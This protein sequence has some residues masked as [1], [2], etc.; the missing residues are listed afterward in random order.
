[1]R[2]LPLPF[3]SCSVHILSACFACVLLDNCSYFLYISGILLP[4][5]LA[6]VDALIFPT[7]HCFAT[8]KKPCAS[9]LRV[10]NPDFS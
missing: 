8:Q 4:H 2:F 9:M 6:A 3:P 1:M 7:G 10:A 5:F